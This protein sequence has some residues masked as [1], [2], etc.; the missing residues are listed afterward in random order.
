MNS[1]LAH[2]RRYFP[3]AATIDS[4]EKAR[5]LL[6][7]LLGILIT[8]LLTQLA[9]GSN[10][11]T[12]WLVAPMGASAVLLFA[13]PASPLAQP[14][15]VIGGNVIS[16]IVGLACAKLIGWPLGTACVAVAAAIAVMFALRC[17]H[18][19]GGAVALT[20]A[21]G[22]PAIAQQGYGFALLPVALNTL[23][24]LAF[25]I[26][27]NKAC[28]RRYPHLAGEHGNSLPT[29]D[30]LPPDRLDITVADL[31]AALK[32]YNQVLDISRD[33]LEEILLRTEV[34][35]YERRFGKKTCGDIMSGDVTSVEFGTTLHHAWGLLREGKLD[36]L[37]VVDRFNRVIGVV[38]QDDF[39]TQCESDATAG[40]AARLRRLLAPAPQTRSDK[41]E[42]VGQ[43]M[44]SSAP[45]A[46]AHQPIASLVPLFSDAGLHRLP[47]VDGND[48]LIGIVTQSALM[49]ALYHSRLEP[50]TAR[51][52][53]RP[54]RVRRIG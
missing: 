1:L 33:D 5:S 42:V 41:P 52:D 23:I 34:Q 53:Q 40:L 35:A 18:P 54:E 48:R 32:Q 44:T 31:D 27:Y 4:R 2:V 30:A 43:I 15:P 20:T 28:G 37:P 47:V 3:E 49:A 38:T 22:G 7:A 9:V 36:A 19:P 10:P 45:T 12:P 46:A 24:L 14:W 21:L 6:G 16:A 26:V 51:A 8:G 39:L 17:V 25:A 29:S 11:I 13:V 50:T